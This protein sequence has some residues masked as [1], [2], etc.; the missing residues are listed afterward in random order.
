LANV[1]ITIRSAR[2]YTTSWVAC[3]AI[4]VRRAWSGRY[5]NAIVAIAVRRMRRGSSVVV[6]RA[7]I[8]ITTITIY[9]TAIANA[10]IIV[11]IATSA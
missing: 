6:G 5:D 2:G 9:C 7:T 11:S 10:I 3:I 8:V 1:A 4:A